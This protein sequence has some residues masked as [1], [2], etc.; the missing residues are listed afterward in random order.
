MKKSHLLF[1]FL[2][3]LLLAGCYFAETDEIYNN[4]GHDL[5]VVKMLPGTNNW[6]TNIFKMGASMRIYPPFY[7]DAH[8]NGAV[9]HYESKHFGRGFQRPVDGSKIIKF[10]KKTGNQILVKMQIEPDGMIYLLPPD[11][12][13][14]STNFPTQP[15]GFPLRPQ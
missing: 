9:W 5:T 2:A 4:S 8:K 15:E 6:T 7:F 1:A 14:I 11:T 3:T 13:G 10:Y 12:T